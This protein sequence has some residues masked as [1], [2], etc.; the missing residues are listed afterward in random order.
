M[1]GPTWLWQVNGQIPLQ[2]FLQPLAHRI[3]EAVDHQVHPYGH[4][5]RHSKRGHC[6]AG[7]AQRRSDGTRPARKPAKEPNI[8]FK[9]IPP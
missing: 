5:K 1:D 7:T 6:N 4:G 2:R 3:P 9:P 8:R